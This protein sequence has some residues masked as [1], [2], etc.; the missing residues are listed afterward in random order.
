MLFCG[1]ALDWNFSSFIISL[2]GEDEVSSL[3]SVSVSHEYSPL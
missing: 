1:G 2:L 3:E